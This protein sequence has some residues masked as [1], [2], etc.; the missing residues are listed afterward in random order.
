MKDRES[1]DVAPVTAERLRQETLERN[2]AALIRD[3]EGRQRRRG[4]RRERQDRMI[5]EQR[6]VGL[7]RRWSRATVWSLVFLAGFLAIVW[8]LA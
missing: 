3:G 4:M 6:R 5:L 8:F 1:T 2:R 7:S